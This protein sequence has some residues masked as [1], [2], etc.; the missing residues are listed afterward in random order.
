M[1]IACVLA[2]NLPIQIEQQRPGKPI[3]LLIT[4]PVDESVIFAMSDDVAEAGVQVG[5]SLYQAKQMAPI[6]LVLEP[7]ELAYH[8]AHGAM[9]SALRAFSP[10]LETVGL[11]EF[12]LDARGLENLYPND[13]ALA[14]AICSAVQ[15]ASNLAIRVALASGKFTAQQAARL[16]PPNHICVIPSGSEA[17]Y[18]APLPISVLPNLPGEIRR[19]MNLLDLH[20]LGD[21]AALRKSAVL[22]QFG[23]EMAGLYELA[24]GHDPRP[25]NPDVPPLRIV[26]SMKLTSPVAER[27]ILLNVVSRIC[28]QMSRVLVDK[29]YHAEALKL[30][31]I[32]EDGQV[33]DVGQSLKPPTADDGRLNRT[34]AQLL[35]RLLVDAPI[36]R[37]VLSTYPLRSWHL[38]THQITLVQ[39]GVPEKELRLEEALQLLYHRFGQA[40]VRIAALLG[41][42]LPIKINVELNDQGLPARLIYGGLDRIIVGIDEHWREERL[43]WERPVQRDYFRTQLADGSLRNIFQ[44]LLTHDWYLDRAWPLL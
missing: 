19:R 6:V 7:D 30:S 44:N 36:E 41:P 34:A 39:A 10:A 33:Y 26:R 2:H 17:H 24:R 38:G 18:L 21:L 22:R 13:D 1:K 11:G 42:P 28:G 4:H 15:L 23:G 16:I 29:G 8:S 20:T 40:I 27:G 37:V 5:M 3:P 9:D 12:L 32:T 43:W 31:L 14:E 25:L 35:G